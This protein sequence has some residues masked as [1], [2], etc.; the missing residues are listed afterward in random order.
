MHNFLLQFKICQEY[1]GTYKVIQEERS[2]F[3][4]LISVIMGEG[5][6]FYMNMSDSGYRGRAD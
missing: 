4:E 2:L 6:E 3:W 1:Y 5:V